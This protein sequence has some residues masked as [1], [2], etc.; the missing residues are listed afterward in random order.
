MLSVKRLSLGFGR[1]RGEI[2]KVIVFTAI[3]D[4]FEVFRIPAVGD[5]DTGDL[6]LF[7]H[8]YCLLFLN[9]GIIGK[10]IPGDSAAFFYKSDDS[11]CVGICMG[12]LIQGLLYKFVSVH[13]HHSFSS[14]FLCK[15]VEKVTEEG[16]R[17]AAEEGYFLVPKV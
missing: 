7:C 11:L 8:V 1:N 2:T 16:M 12:N 13:D 15:V 6:P 9:N 14:Y 3:G 4:G 5:A 17:S 10:L